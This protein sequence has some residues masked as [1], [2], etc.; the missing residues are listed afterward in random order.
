MRKRNN[1]EGTPIKYPGVGHRLVHALVIAPDLRALRPNPRAQRGA[2]K[3]IA[4][5]G[6]KILAR[7]RQCRISKEMKIS[8]QLKAW[9]N[10]DDS[11]NGRGDFTQHEAAD[12]LGVPVKTYVD[13]EQGRRGPLGIAL[14][15][16]EERIKLRPGRTAGRRP[17]K[18]NPTK[19]PPRG[20][21]GAA[22][23][24]SVSENQ[25]SNKPKQRQRRRSGK[26]AAS[27]SHA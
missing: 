21:V 1:R 18:S 15:A 4:T 10:V 14:Q 19:A 11:K 3:G 25:K 26:R 12:F 22:S 5:L 24:K 7:I 8:T 2:M 23:K 27:M 13:W 6:K 17:G 16:V 9:R 20:S